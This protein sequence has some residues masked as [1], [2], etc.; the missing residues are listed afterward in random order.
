MRVC[1]HSGFFFLIGA[2]ERGL[3]SGLDTLKSSTILLG[4]CFLTSWP[5]TQESL[6]FFFIFNLEYNMINVSLGT[7]AE[8]IQLPL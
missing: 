4:Y 8:N 6:F 5:A 2:L 3:R 7:L 1:M